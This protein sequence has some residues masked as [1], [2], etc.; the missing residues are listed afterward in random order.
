MSQPRRQRVKERVQASSYAIGNQL[1]SLNIFCN[2]DFPNYIDPMEVR[3]L[4][5]WATRLYVTMFAGGLA[6]L[7]LYTI[8][9][10][11]TQNIIH[12]KPSYNLYNRLIEQYG[13]QLKCPC[14][15]IAMPYRQLVSIRPIFHEVV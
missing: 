15:T 5:Q 3:R 1:I 2:R 6:I 4:G 11:R 10:P 12:E 14:S 7:A 8:L 13:D 9:Q